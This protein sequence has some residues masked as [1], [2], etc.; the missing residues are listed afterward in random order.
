M[1][2]EEVRRVAREQ[3]EGEM[4]DA[5]VKAEIERLKSRRPWWHTVFP[6]EIIV[7]RRK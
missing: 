5:A 7:R 1:D 2:L 6:F 3:L 4:F